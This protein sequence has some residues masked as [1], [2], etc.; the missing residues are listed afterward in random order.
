MTDV[1]GPPYAGTDMDLDELD[2]LWERHP[3]WRL[4]RARNA[5]LVLAFLG[6]QF[7]DDNR[8]AVPAGELVAALEDFLY[9][10]HRSDPER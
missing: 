8:G 3:A 6:W 4:L 7:I 1:A 10:V 5:P 9:A 2:R